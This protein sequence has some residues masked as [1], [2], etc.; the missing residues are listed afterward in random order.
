M[1]RVAVS[2]MSS[3]SRV[4]INERGPKVKGG[5][6]YSIHTISPRNLN[7][8]VR[9][10]T[11]L[12]TRSRVF[13]F[14]SD[15]P[16][17]RHRVL[18]EFGPCAGVALGTDHRPLRAC[19]FISSWL[20]H[21]LQTSS[22]G[23]FLAGLRFHF[24]AIFRPHPQAPTACCRSKCMHAR[25][26]LTFD[27]L[28]RGPCPSSRIDRLLASLCSSHRCPQFSSHSDQHSLGWRHR[29]RS[30]C[31]SYLTGTLNVRNDTVGLAAPWQMARSGGEWGF[32]V[33]RQSA[34]WTTASPQEWIA[35]DRGSEAVVLSWSSGV[36]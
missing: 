27:H 18:I 2:Q 3:P 19:P 13:F 10:P 29:K 14:D 30:R 21:F 36:S 35:V 1:T 11:C 28:T 17:Q 32:H 33:S 22:T 20:Q 8:A 26:P 4:L 15:E 25:V 34:R 7:A 24:D 12:E 5:R 9:A 16:E 31:P 23:G 6:R